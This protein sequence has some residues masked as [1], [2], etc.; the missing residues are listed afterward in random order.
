MNETT[1]GPEPERDQA[2]ID[3]Q[4]VGKAD[5]PVSEELAADDLSAQLEEASREKEQFKRLAQRSQA[6]LINYRKR[7]QQD[8]EEGQTRAVR[9]M[10]LR[11]LDVIDQLDV[12]LAPDV[13]KG[14]DA[15]WV[16]GVKA[17]H[18]NFLHAVQ[19]EGFERFD[20]EGEQFDPARHEA[21]ISTPTTEH[22]PGTVIRQLV[23][24]YTHKG[25]VVRPARVEIAAPPPDDTDDE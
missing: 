9:R 25:D 19:Q 14:V 1:S 11:V 22:S 3:G 18:R 6:D 17:I 16:A 23:A 12:A 15:T 7:V 2:D 24:G 8:A 5:A 4:K 13:T 10:A 21:L 20:A